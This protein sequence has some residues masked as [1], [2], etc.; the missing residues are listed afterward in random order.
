MNL[1]Q[2]ARDALPQESVAALAAWLGE[3]VSA[4]DTALRAGALPASLAGL[5]R[6]FGRDETTVR[7]LSDLLRDGGYDGSLLDGLPAALCGGTATEALILR[8]QGL[9]TLLFGEQVT[10]VS[11]LIGQSSGL[12]PASSQKLLGLAV[13]LMLAVIAR[14][15]ASAGLGGAQLVS[16]LRNQQPALQSESPVGLIA[17]LGVRDFAPAE[18]ELPRK[19][20]LWPWLLVPGIT[21]ALFFVLRWIQHSSMRAP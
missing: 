9:H 7:R 6:Q 3:S 20:A 4:T 21:L 5:V 1:L 2:L 14:S 18:L 11:A 8:G 17:A 13:P 10:A 19:P 12:R 16:L 15:C